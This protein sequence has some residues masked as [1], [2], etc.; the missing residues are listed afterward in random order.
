MKKV[1]AACNVFIAHGGLEMGKRKKFFIISL[2]FAFCMVF[3][4]SAGIMAAENLKIGVF[5]MHKI[6][7]ES[8]TAQGYRQKLMA[9]FEAK[10][11]PL[12]G[13]DAYARQLENR[14]KNDKNISPAERKSTEDKLASEVRDLKRM[15]EDLDAEFQKVDRDLGRQALMEISE[16]VKKIAEKDGYTL[17]LEKNAGGVVYSKDAIDITSKILGDYDEKGKK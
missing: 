11:K 2:L 15:K 12:M 16:V 8:K 7:K 4:G 10:R 3:T 14:L 9:Q 13:K 5:D 17:V 1:Y 6:M